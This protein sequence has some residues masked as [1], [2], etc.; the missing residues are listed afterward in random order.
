[1]SACS[2]EDDL[3]PTQ[4]VD[5]QPVGLDMAL[6]PSLLLADELVITMERIKLLP[7]NKGA[8]DHFELL[9]VLSSLLHPSDIP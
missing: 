5:Q 1:V 2:L 7:R 9:K 4:L 6:S 8:D 3:I